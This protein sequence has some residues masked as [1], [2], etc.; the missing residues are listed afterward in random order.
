[1]TYAHDADGGVSV[2]GGYVYRG[3][4]EGMEGRYVYADFVSNHL[5]SFRIVDGR[6]IDVTEHAEQLAG[7]AVSNVTSFAED[8]RGNLYVIGIGGTIARLDFSAAAGDGADTLS[9]GAGS[10]RM[11]GGAGADVISGAAGSDQLYGGE[12][13]DDL[14]RRRAER[15]PRRR[16]G[17]TTS[18][19]AARAPTPSTAAQATT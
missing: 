11:Y 10:D 7:A 3:Q 5:W 2:I 14:S 8:G 9:G 15:R 19:A 4:S 16:P 6:A 13:D 17:A 12:G 1:M 18:C